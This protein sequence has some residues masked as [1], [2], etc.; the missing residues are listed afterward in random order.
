MQE[1]INIKHVNFKIKINLYIYI[2]IV[3]N[4]QYSF[5]EDLITKIM[6]KLIFFVLLLYFIYVI[7]NYYCPKII[8][9][10]V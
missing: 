6:M 4:L 7:K 8:D 3:L 1:L 9:I 10:H 5:D 2:Y